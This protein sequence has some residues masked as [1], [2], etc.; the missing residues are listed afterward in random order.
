MLTQYTGP[1]LF[2]KHL[3][4]TLEKLETVK[5]RVKGDEEAEKREE[6]KAEELLRKD[7]DWWQQI[8]DTESGCEE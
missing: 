8:F 3:K 5:D 7:S 2:L 4:S 6:R 1:R